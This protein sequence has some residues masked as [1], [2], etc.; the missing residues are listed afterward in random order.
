MDSQNIDNI[1]E[2]NSSRE[3]YISTVTAIDHINNKIKSG[4]AVIASYQS[5]LTNPQNSSAIKRNNHPVVNDY[6]LAFYGHSRGTF[7]SFMSNWSSHPVQDTQNETITIGSH[8]L[9][10]QGVYFPTS[11]H[12]MMWYKALLFDPE[13]IE[14]L[15]AIATA[16]TPAKVKSLGRKIA[17]YDDTIWSEVRLQ[18]VTRLVRLKAQQH[19]IIMATLKQSGDLYI[20]EASKWDHIWGVGMNAKDAVKYYIENPTKLKDMVNQQKNLLGKAWMTVRSEL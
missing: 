13:N 12:G 14:Q 18:L 4:E 15:H 3:A 5:W 9:I 2:C 19:P 7:A 11:E 20:M 17:N 8:T 1:M 16:N 10:S 6:F